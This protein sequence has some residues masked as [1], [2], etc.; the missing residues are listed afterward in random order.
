MRSTGMMTGMPETPWRYAS[1]GSQRTV[2][3]PI[4]GHLELRLRHRPGHVQAISVTRP[5]A[6]QSRS[7]DLVWCDAC[8]QWLELHVTS[9]SGMKTRRRVAVGVCVFAVLV[10][11]IVGYV[12]VRA[13]TPDSNGVFGTVYPLALA[14][15][16]TVIA[17]IVVGYALRQVVD[18]G[19]DAPLDG[20][21]E[22]SP[23]RV[24]EYV[25]RRCGHA[26]YLDDNDGYATKSEVERAA[27]QRVRAAFRAHACAARP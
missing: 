22:I 27:K 21:H 24:P 1:A 18:S 6:V 25:C 7:T 2:F 5:P 8:P 23:P 11:G 9:L 17:A 14:G 20:V 3:D 10:V 15:A 26:E 12:V 19:V 4:R 13:G 16:M